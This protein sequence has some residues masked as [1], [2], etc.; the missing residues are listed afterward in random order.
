MRESQTGERDSSKRQEREQQET[1]ERDSQAGEVQ[2]WQRDP[3]KTAHAARALKMGVTSMTTCF[4]HYK[5]RYGFTHKS[6]NL[7]FNLK[8]FRTGDVVLIC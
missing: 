5:E 1:G 7:F 8:Y 4:I 3:G 6:L 2:R